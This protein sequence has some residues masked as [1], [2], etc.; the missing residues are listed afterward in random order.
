M[1]DEL[2]T[3]IDANVHLTEVA[4]THFGENTQLREQLEAVKLENRCH[5]LRITANEEA[6]EQQTKII[7]R[8][9]REREEAPVVY[10]NKTTY[11]NGVGKHWDERRCSVD[12]HQARL[13]AIQEIKK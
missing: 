8:L 5:L 10:W 6:E 4:K 1:R 7:D 3:Q 13:I 12:T 9:T 2:R 11:D